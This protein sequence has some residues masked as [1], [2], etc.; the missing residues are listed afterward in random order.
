MSSLE[1][2]MGGLRVHAGRTRARFEILSAFPRVV[3]YAACWN[4]APLLPYFLRHYHW[5]EKIVLFD[6][7]SDD[8]S[9]EVAARFSNV[10][11]R[12]METNVYLDEPALIHMKNHAW[13]ESRGANVDFVIVV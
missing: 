10:E 3:V 13:K 1:R 12:T 9:K 2:E 7:E 5:A 11:W 8:G 4:E 6:N